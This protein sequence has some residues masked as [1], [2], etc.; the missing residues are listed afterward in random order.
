MDAKEKDALIEKLTA[1]MKKP[2]RS[3]ILS[4]PLTCATVLQR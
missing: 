4:V 3:L 2:L 1:E